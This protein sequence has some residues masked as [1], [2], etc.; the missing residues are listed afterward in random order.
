MKTYSYL[1][2]ITLC[3]VIILACSAKAPE[4]LRLDPEKNLINTVAVLQV[5]NKTKDKIAP[6]LIRSKIMDELYFK[7][8]E[9]LSPDLID[10]KLKFLENADR[11]ENLSSV[12]P[13]TLKGLLNADAILYSRLD[14]SEKST[15]LF[16]ALLTISLSC[17]MRKSMN[18][19][20][21]WREN[22]SATR[23]NFAFTRNGLEMK[24]HKVYEEMIEEIVGEIMQTIPYGPNLRG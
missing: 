22:R 5:E 17:E 2:A 23:R 12:R 13:E 10:S 8:Y 16:Y 20:V 19:E 7:G 18:G 21:I 4:N 15:K 11:K 24:C 6:A 9:R 14:R 3:I 1:V